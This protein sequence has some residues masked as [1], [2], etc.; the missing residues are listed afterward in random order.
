VTITETH[1]DVG[2][3][4]GAALV[5]R[6]AGGS[7][8]HVIERDDGFVDV[9]DADYYFAEPGGWATIDRDALDLVAGR[10]LDVGAGAGRHALAL[11]ERGEDVLALDVSPG[12]IE[13][14][15]RRGVGRTFLGTPQDLATTAP[16]LFDTAILM[17]NGLG[18]LGS[19]SSAGGI[20]NAL[21]SL[22]KRDGVV[23]GTILDPYDTDDARHLAYHDHNRRRGRLPGEVTI[24]TRFGSLADPWFDW[25]QASPGEL[26]DLAARHSWRIDAATEPSPSYLVVLRPS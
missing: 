19:R 10:V 17:G 24:R 23:V 3:A 20:L 26:R 11:Q 16:K 25:L 7:G 5:D 6:L 4:F 8:T 1:P 21:R 14:C 9:M 12:A 13:T 2:D 22:M 18:L 15:R